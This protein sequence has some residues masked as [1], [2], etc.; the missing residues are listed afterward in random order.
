[1]LRRHTTCWFIA[2][3]GACKGAPHHAPGE[4]PH[5]VD[6]SV[7]ASVEDAASADG[8]V[9]HDAGAD[10]GEERDASLPPAPDPEFTRALVVPPVLAPS[11][12]DQ[13]TDYYEL[14]IEAGSA[15][16]RDGAATP[17]VGFNGM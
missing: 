3:L 1:M 14:S 11:S 2:L 8:S 7:D 6:A 17:I 5:V 16:M 10:A 9:G 15:Q 4:P 13:T 12:S